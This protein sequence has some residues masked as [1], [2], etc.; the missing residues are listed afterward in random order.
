MFRTIGL[1]ELSI[2]LVVLACSGAL[3]LIPAIFYLI[4]LQR[5]LERCAPESRAMPPGQVWLLLIPLFNVVWQFI[6]VNSIAVS[7]RNEFARRRIPLAEG[8]PGKPIGFVLCIATVIG[9]V[10]LVNILAGPVS[11]VCWILYWVKISGYSRML[12]PPQ[13]SVIVS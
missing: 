9:I 10:P 12:L 7:L 3:L 6:V 4:T 13:A 11:L 1:P 5:A 8:E 2:V